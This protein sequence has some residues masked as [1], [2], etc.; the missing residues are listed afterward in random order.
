[1][2]PRGAPV[3][4][5][6]APHAAVDVPHRQQLHRSIRVEIQRRKYRIRAEPRDGEASPVVR[7]RRRQRLGEGHDLLL[8]LIA[9]AGQALRPRGGAGAHHGP[10]EELG[11]DLVGEGIGEVVDRP[12]EAGHEGPGHGER[13][14][15]RR[16]LGGRL[17]EVALGEVV[18]PGAG[19]GD[20][21]ARAGARAPDARVHGA[22]HAPPRRGAAGGRGGG[23]G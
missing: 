6:E 9:G 3:D 10:E 19:G 20:L 5:P 12:D 4:V 1:M 21:D 23:G 17:L 15:G 18:H 2:P 22:E 11:D 13:G 16:G 7:V 8:R 14:E